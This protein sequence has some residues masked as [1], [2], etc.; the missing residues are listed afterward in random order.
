[1][2]NLLAFFFL[3][4]ISCKSEVNQ[5]Q[6]IK[7]NVQ[8]KTGKWIEQD[9]YPDQKY[10]SIGKYKKGEKVGVWKVF[11]NGK[12]YQ[13]DRF[14]DSITHTKFYYTNGKTL[15][16]GIS[17]TIRDHKSIFWYYDG[18]WKFYDENGNLE[19]IKTYYKDSSKTDSINVKKG[20]NKN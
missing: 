17:K 20:L 11:L 8:V 18:K 15:K 12:I 2:K 4:L 1:M 5:Y 19:Y 3:I 14:K 7:K 13:K 10:V 6:N 16:K 9:D